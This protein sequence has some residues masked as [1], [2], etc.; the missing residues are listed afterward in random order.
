[1]A[2][3]KSAAE[4]PR[5]SGHG[6]MIKSASA[7]RAA[8]SAPAAAVTAGC[9]TALAG[10]AGSYTRIGQ[11]CRCAISASDGEFLVEWV[12]SLYAKPKMP[13]VGFGGGGRF[14]R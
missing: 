1:M 8:S 11:F 3:A 12:F 14:P 4:S 2:A 9:T 7:P 6:V 5:N 13:N 10:T